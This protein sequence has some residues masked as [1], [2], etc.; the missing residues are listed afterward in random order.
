MK[1]I[2]K[3]GLFDR[4]ESYTLPYDEY[5]RQFCENWNKRLR[6]SPNIFEASYGEGREVCERIISE[7]SCTPPFFEG[8]P[9]S[10]AN[11][12]I[13]LYNVIN[14]NIAE[15]NAAEAARNAFDAGMNYELMRL[16]FT[17]EK[18]AERGAKVL[19]GS[20][21]SA[22]ERNREHAMLREKRFSRLRELTAQGGMNLASAAAQCEVEGLGRQASILQQWHRAK[23]RLR[24]R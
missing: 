14:R 9:E 13:I 18:D 2:M 22:R 15:G 19:G 3:G 23:K 6:E 16:K 10:F 4:R 21:N 8:T 24:A 17:F 7:S 20:Q 5:L 11:T 12:I 1:R